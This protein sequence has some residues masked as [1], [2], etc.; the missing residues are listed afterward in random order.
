[1]PS[2]SLLGMRLLIHVGSKINQVSPQEELKINNVAQDLRHSFLSL[3]ALFL[4]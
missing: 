3:C 2:H 4:V 1:M